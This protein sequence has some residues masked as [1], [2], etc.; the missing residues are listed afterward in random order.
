MADPISHEELKAAFLTAD[1]VDAV[2][3]IFDRSFAERVA[4]GRKLFF[5]ELG[6]E[7]T[8]DGRLAFHFNDDPARPALREMIA[9]RGDPAALARLFDEQP[10]N[11]AIL[12]AQ[13]LLKRHLA[14]R[15]RWDAEGRIPKEKRD[16]VLSMVVD[17]VAESAAAHYSGNFATQL[18]TMTRDD[19]SGRY[20]GTWHCHPPD[21]TPAGWVDDYPPSDA[22]YDAAA[23]TGQELV[24]TFRRDG[25]DV[26]DLS[27][28][29]SVGNPAAAFS[30]RSAAWRAHFDGVFSALSR[31]TAAP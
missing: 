21:F 11:M 10:A 16:A 6:G 8:L 25:F 9:R 26:Y 18:K 20:A 2:R 30:Y 19:W 24:V 29:G 22:D 14:V 12:D 27:S 28:G 4:V 1:A 17:T 23:K 31:E 13:G 15:A 3:G 7:A 5:P